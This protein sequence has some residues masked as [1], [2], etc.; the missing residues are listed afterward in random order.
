MAEYYY[1][2]IY[3]PKCFITDEVKKAIKDKLTKAEEAIV[4]AGIKHGIYILAY[5]NLI[6]HELQYYTTQDT[7]IP[8]SVQFAYEQ[9]KEYGESFYDHLALYILRTDINYPLN[10]E[11]A[12]KI[13]DDYMNENLAL[14]PHSS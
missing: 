13:L 2:K 5:L 14:T 10:N 9:L 7:D 8:A 11:G 6:H 3:I 1:T 12:L 4:N